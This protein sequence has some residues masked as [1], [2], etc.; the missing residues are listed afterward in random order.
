MNNLQVSARWFQSF[1]P[2]NLLLKSNFSTE[3]I[4]MCERKSDGGSR[5]RKNKTYVSKT[6]WISFWG[7]RQTL[8]HRSHSHF[9]VWP[10]YYASSQQINLYCVARVKCPVERPKKV[11]SADSACTVNCPLPDE[12]THTGIVPRLVDNSYLHVVF[13]FIWHLGFLAAIFQFTLE[14]FRWECLKL[15]LLHRIF[16]INVVL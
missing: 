12:A 16:R 7:C 9:S 1:W 15:F 2:C 4:N 3:H 11:P 13:C 6:D 10:N 8:N 5:S 14:L